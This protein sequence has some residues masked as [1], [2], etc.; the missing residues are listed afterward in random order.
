M[1]W[2]IL[3]ETAAAAKAKVEFDQKCDLFTI[4]SKSHY[5]IQI[6]F[7]DV[8][9]YSDMW[10][11]RCLDAQCLEITRKK[12]H[13]T[14]STLWYLIMYFNFIYPNP[15]P[16]MYFINLD[17]IFWRASFLIASSPSLSS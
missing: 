3:A 8:I 17:V 9:R 13:F 15:N 6:V 1:A 2:K 12:S 14:I 4:S 7:F 5:Y 11:L 16:Y 10:I